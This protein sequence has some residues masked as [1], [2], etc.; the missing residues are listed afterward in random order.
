MA[1]KN[2]WVLNCI[3]S[4]RV[5]DDWTFQA[6]VSA[7]L[8]KKTVPIP[9]RK[10]LRQSWWRIP[11]Q[12]QSGSCVGWATADGLFRWH[13]VK[14]RKLSKANRISVRYVWMSAKETDEFINFPTT[15]IETAGTRVKAA[16]SVARHYGVVKHSLLPFRTRKLYQRGTD[17]FY[18]KASQMKIHSYY[19]LKGGPEEWRTWIA[20]QGPLIVA[21][22]VDDAFLS[23]KKET[24]SLREYNGASTHGGHA[25]LLVGYTEK[26]FILRNSWGRSWGDRGFAYLHDAYAKAAF[27]EAYGIKV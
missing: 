7:G 6:A 16:L 10:D 2:G 1:N 15:F 19:H 3:N 25:A 8:I 12:G 5:E 4:H 9:K 18:G 27:F 26:Y 20:Q 24:A 21:L 14:A 23:A 13:F 17:A 22:I 11:D